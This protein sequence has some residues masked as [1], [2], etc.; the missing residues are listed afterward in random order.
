MLPVAWWW[1]L[2]L[3]FSLVGLPFAFHLFPRLPDRGYA[4]GRLLTLLF[5]SYILWLL[6]SARILPNSLTTL[7]LV[8]AALTAFSLYLCWRQ[9]HQMAAFLSREWPAI[10]ITEAI[11]AGAIFLW[12]VVR[13]YTPDLI[14][15]EKLMD[16]G[17][18]NV[19]WRAPYFPPPDPWLSGHSV[20][21]YYFGYVMMSSA[22]K[23]TGVPPVI[24]YNVAIS[25]LFALV[26]TGV[27]CL[28][29]NLVRLRAP[30]RP[31]RATVF[32]L[33]GVGLFLLLGNLEGF[34][35]I[36]RAHGVGTPGFWQWFGIKGLTAS[37]RSD[38][39]FPTDHWWWWRATRLI[40]TVRGGISLDYTIIEFPFFT[41]LFGDLH[42]HAMALPF[43]LL[44]VGLS[45]NVFMSHH[46]AGLSCV[47]R[48][49]LQ[50]LAIAVAMGALGFLNTW[51]LPT[52]LAV[53]LAAL[54]LRTYYAGQRWRDWML[55][56]IAITAASVVV[57]LPFYL[58]LKS[59]VSGVWPWFGP[60]TR[61]V[62]YFLAWGLLLF[63]AVSF[64]LTKAIRDA[65]WRGW[66]KANAWLV[67]AAAL[68]ALYPLILWLLARASLSLLAP[69]VAGL[70]SPWGKV[71]HLLPLLGI[72]GLALTVL[73]RR[74]QG[75]AGHDD[76]DAARFAVVLLFMGLLIT[77]AAELFYLRDS[78]GTR[79]NTVFKFYYQ[80]WALLGIGSAFGVYYVVEHWRPAAL[81]SRALR[82][83]WW[84]ALALLVVMAAAY[85]LAAMFTFTDSFQRERT[86]DGLAFV[87]REDPG[88]RQAIAF[89]TRQPGSPVLVE[90]VGS[91]VNTFGRISVRTG[92]PAVMGSGS[93]E[94]QWRGA[95]RILAERQSDV[96]T[97]YTSRDKATVKALLDKYNVTFVYVGRL[98]RA[99]YASDVGDKFE[100]FLRIAYRNRDVTIYEVPRR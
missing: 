37:Y 16:F 5:L 39:W 89:L 87:E 77:M 44:A 27:Y 100:E 14:Y 3:L 94:V 20:S 70:P 31:G 43:T 90:A 69:G 74:G 61:Y 46:A 73:L 56:A 25:L 80:A 35:E 86:L 82:W 30:E 95:H 8:L 59:Q 67:I 99:A 65:A 92:L 45:L 85:P 4:F 50:F 47:R 66:G 7:V 60:D 88:E 18:L 34:L 57:Y 75:E 15:G 41:Y 97:I 6:A 2:F 28:V 26:A 78:F 98:E 49:P 22:T 54:L 24:A 68:I 42:P 79:M 38:E 33:L 32:G 55:S 53:F 1:L 51:D 9:R 81:W 29:S 11:F 71:W 10:T 17:F 93:H 48:R 40:D 58:G 96:Y 13:S 72:L 64:V 91:D 63:L 19:T 62:H 83:L 84:R 12:A 21:Y 23:L 36:L 52:Y 76:K